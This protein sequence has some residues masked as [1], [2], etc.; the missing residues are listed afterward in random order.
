MF[1]LNDVTR[2]TWPIVPSSNE[3][4]GDTFL[5]HVHTEIENFEIQIF[6]V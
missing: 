6:G 4:I 3:I 5:Q 2:P 1:L